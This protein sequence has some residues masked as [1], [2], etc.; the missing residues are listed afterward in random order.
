MHQS[1]TSLTQNYDGWKSFFFSFFFLVHQW[2]GL[3]GQLVAKISNF[4]TAFP[5]DVWRPMD[6]NAGLCMYVQTDRQTDRQIG[7]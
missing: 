5:L 7:L 3:A 4:F 2:Y 1:D 6:D